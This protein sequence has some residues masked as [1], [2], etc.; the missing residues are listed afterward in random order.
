[1]PG[2]REAFRQGRDEARAARGAPP[3]PREEQELR[4]GE[5]ADGEPADDTAQNPARIAELEASLRERDDEIAET[6][7][8]L[9][10][11]TEFAEQMQSRVVELI[12]G[13]EP[14]AKV[15]LLPGVKTFLLQ[16]FHPDKHPTADNE[17][18][19]LLTA[20]LQTIT[21]AYGLAKEIRTQ[22]SD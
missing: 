10:E 7:R 14:M 19:E 18:H 4:P 12:A 15:L 2:F 17:Q 3:L 22:T 21:T 1:M 13:A 6:K 20:A 8:L 11:V 9:A 16:R 5:W